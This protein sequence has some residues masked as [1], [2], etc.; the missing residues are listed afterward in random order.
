[1]EGEIY[2]AL[3]SDDF[4]ASEAAGRIKY[5]KFPPTGDITAPYIVIDPLTPGQASDFADNTW[6][7]DDYLYQIDV[8]TLNR[9]RTKELAKRV[10]KVLDV[11]GL[12][13]HKSGVD[14]WDEDTGIFRIA[15]RYSGKKYNENIE[16]DNDE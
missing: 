2:E 15:R 5:Y 9:M 4:I 3:M 12:R 8:M 14:E 6:L 10:R 13:E 11:I 1:M 16:E 7:T